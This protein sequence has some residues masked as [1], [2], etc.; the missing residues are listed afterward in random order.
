LES[1]NERRV[2]GL[3]A[4]AVYT[5]A[6]TNVDPNYPASR[7]LNPT[8]PRRLCRALTTAATYVA[9][10]LAANGAAVPTVAAITAENYNVNWFT[11]DWSDNGTTWTAFLNSVIA[12]TRDPDDGRRKR[13]F[14]FTPWTHRY[15]RV[16]LLSVFTGESPLCEIG[17]LCFWT[18]LTTVG[19]NIAVPYEKVAESRAEELEYGGGGEDVGV[20]S[21]IRLRLRLQANVK[22]SD[23]TTATQYADFCRAP[24]NRVCLFHEN[25]G[26]LTKIY[27]ARRAGDATI[28]RGNDG[29]LHFTGMDLAE[30]V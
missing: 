1:L 23:T 8:R 18:A 15:V 9:F 5:P 28:S 13:L 16:Q 4:M 3:P 7:L 10:D 27:H 29:F 14:T 30:V 26:D 20:P 22:R 6:Q 2:S 12:S 19:K 24:R 25:E 21:P 17:L 11:G